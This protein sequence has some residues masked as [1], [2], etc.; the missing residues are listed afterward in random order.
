MKKLTIKEFRD[1]SNV[2]VI[3]EFMKKIMDILLQNNLIFLTYTGCSFKLCKKKV[4]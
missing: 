1:K 3:K 2:E 4:L